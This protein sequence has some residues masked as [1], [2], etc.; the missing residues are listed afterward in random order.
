MKAW[1]PEKRSP[2]SKDRRFWDLGADLNEDRA[3]RI[4]RLP[5]GASRAGNKGLVIH[6][7]DTEKNPEGLEIIQE[8]ASSVSDAY[9]IVFR[10]TKDGTAQG[11]V[12]MSDGDWATASSV[13]FK[14]N[15]KEVPFSVLQKVATKLKVQS[16]NYKDSPTE[17]FIGPTAEDFKASNGLWGR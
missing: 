16:W 2:G 7:M 12:R 4:Y 14:E 13:A 17:R 11:Y 9:P 15:F 8:S 3:L 10:R 5:C 1:Y 6:M